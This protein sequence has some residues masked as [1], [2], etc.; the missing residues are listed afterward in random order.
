[1]SKLSYCFFVCCALFGCSSPEQSDVRYVDIFG[2]GDRETMASK[3]LTYRM[4]IPAGW[5]II[6][7]ETD[8]SLI[9]TTEPLLTLT[10]EDVTITF[11]N[12]P[13][14]SVAERVP[15]LSQIARW[16]N[17]FS[18]LDEASLEITPYS[19]AGFTGFQFTATGV[20][21]EKNVKVV[22]WILQLTPELFQ[23]LPHGSS[24]DKADWTLKAVGPP[25][26]LFYLEDEVKSIARSV[27]LIAEIP[28][29]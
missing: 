15:P 7:P 6:S 17:Q 29:R 10:K 22:A 16:K 8:A 20:Q 2:R 28:G 9:D 12:F 26:H 23:K 18:Q 19:V 1:M 11:H 14:N 27:E 3:K 25:E 4:G 5:N 24:Q 13:V 21:K